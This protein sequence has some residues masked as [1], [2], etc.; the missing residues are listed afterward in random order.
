MQNRTPLKNVDPSHP[1]NSDKASERGHLYVF[2]GPDDVGKTTFATMLSAYLSSS[3]LLNQVLSFPGREPAT[4][5]ELI[6]RL[7]H[8]PCG[9]SVMSILPITMQVMVTAAHIEVIEARVKPLLNAGV[10]VILDRFWWST[11]VYATQERVPLR[12]RD[13]LIDIEMECWGDIK[14]DV[15]FLV[16]RDEPLLTQADD[17]RWLELAQLYKQLSDAQ[18]ELAPIQLVM[19]DRSESDAFGTIIS[20]ISPL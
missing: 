1:L 20:R 8:D 5:S 10:N 13:L 6:Y 17:Q 19:N 15:L 4:I 14:P 9:L 18:S 2:E 11:W 16:M 7:Y 12:T 3:E